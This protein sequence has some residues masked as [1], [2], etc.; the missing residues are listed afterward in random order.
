MS[1]ASF[2]SPSLSW[3]SVM[4]SLYVAAEE[5]ACFGVG[6]GAKESAVPLA[7]TVNAVLHLE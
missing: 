7:I 4:S 5:I 1:E 6:G 3:Q 2:S